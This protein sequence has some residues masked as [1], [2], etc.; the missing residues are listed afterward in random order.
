MKWGTGYK[1]Q[2]SYLHSQVTSETSL[3]T[4][5]NS[6][7]ITKHHKLKEMLKVVAVC[8]DNHLA[9]YLII[10]EKL[11]VTTDLRIENS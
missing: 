10:Q 4:E 3:M 11:E 2:N 6:F 8:S 1:I 7:V 9:T 5:V